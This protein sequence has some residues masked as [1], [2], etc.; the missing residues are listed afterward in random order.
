MLDVAFDAP[1]RTARFVRRSL[2]GRPHRDI[3]IVGAGP[4]GLASAMLLARS[5]ANVTVLEREAHV[6]GRTSAFTADGFT[7]DMGPT[8]FLYPEILA[9]IFASCGRK[10]E[11]EVDLIRLDPMYD[12]VFESGGSVRATA[13]IERLQAEVA[14]F[15]EADAAKVPA[16]IEANRRKFEAFRPILQRP[17]I[18]LRG[19]LN[20]DVLRAAHLVRPWASV[21]TDLKRWFEN[22]HVRL[23]F[24]FQSKYLGMSPFKCPSLFTILS[25]VEYGYGVFHPRGGCGSISEAMARVATDMGVDIRLNEPVESID[26]KGRRAVGARTAK[27]HYPA[28]AMIIN[29]DFANAMQRLVPNRLRKHWNDKRIASRQYSCSTC[30]LYLGVRGRFDHL[31]HHTISLSEDYVGNIRDIEAHRA[32]ADPTLYVQN[33]SVT[34]PSLAPEGCSTFYVLAP[35]G[36][37]EGGEDWATLAPRYRKLLLRRLSSLLGV[38]DIEDDIVFER[39]VTP[40]D[41]ENRYDIY[42][43]ATFNLAHNLG[44]ML[45]WRPQNRFQDLDRVYLTGGGTH[46]GSG[47]PTIFESARIAS[48]LLA[49]D[50]DLDADYLN[51]PLPTE[52]A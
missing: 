47:L 25:H 15:S 12:L 39:M 26:F 45:N 43:G 18:G 34:D 16:F 49:R 48:R 8:F 22:P 52:K 13:D 5:G 10:L 2:F 28:D 42:R 32:P 36:N 17:F 30:M 29:A 51:Q 38:D 35:V 37:N 4:G 1:A 14:R 41:W 31:H 50:I 3:V 11:D 46:P 21:D 19:L 7:F 27:G 9:E 6:G 23:A 24:S 33:A 20:A 44:Q 40:A